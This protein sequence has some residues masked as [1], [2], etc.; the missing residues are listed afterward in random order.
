MVE[1]WKNR[2]TTLSI[3]FIQQVVDKGYER[4]EGLKKVE[5]KLYDEYLVQEKKEQAKR[6][7][8]ISVQHNLGVRPSN[9]E[10]TNGVISSNANE[11][12]LKVQQKTPEQ[13][14][15]EKIQLLNDIKA[16][17]MNKKISLADASKLA[18]DI[19]IAYGFYNGTSEG[20]PNNSGMHK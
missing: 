9:I 19:N 16:K 7:A 12:H 17:V 3:A 18:N 10:I 13:L 4:L 20:M 1:S 5:N 8:D 15:M 14:E 2:E 6:I 11:S